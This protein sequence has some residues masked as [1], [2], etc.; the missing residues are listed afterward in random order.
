MLDP[1]EDSKQKVGDNK[2]KLK[3][4]FTNSV[5]RTGHIFMFSMLSI[6]Y[7]RVEKA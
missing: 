6:I 2:A 3:T 7:K 4:S 5:Q 1:F